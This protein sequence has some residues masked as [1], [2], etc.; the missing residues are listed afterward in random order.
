MCGFFFCLVVTVQRMKCGE[1]EVHGGGAA[2]A[3]RVAACNRRSG[4]VDMVRRGLSMDC[5]AEDSM[6]LFRPKRR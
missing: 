4:S 1:R 2:E 3:R 5:P 6:R